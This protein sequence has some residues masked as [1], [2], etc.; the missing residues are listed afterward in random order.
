[1]SVLLPLVLYKLPQHQKMCE[2]RHQ[3]D[4]MNDLKSF[5]KSLLT[6]INQLQKT[7]I[8]LV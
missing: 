8:K 5:S 1:M 2:R 6:V 3:S 7:Q 4:V